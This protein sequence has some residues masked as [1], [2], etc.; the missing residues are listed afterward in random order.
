[1]IKPTRKIPGSGMARKLIS[2]EQGFRATFSKIG[3][4]LVQ[5]EN[6][7]FVEDF[8]KSSQ[9]TSWRP[10]FCACGQV[11]VDKS[12]A[13]LHARLRWKQE[14]D[15]LKTN[16]SW[17]FMQNIFEQLW[18]ISWTHLTSQ[19]I[20]VAFEFKNFPKGQVI[21]LSS[22]LSSAASAM[23]AE[24]DTATAKRSPENA[25]GALAE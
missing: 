14:T 12:K 24:D 25:L 9:L 8:L 15:N 16:I 2:S 1:M 3:S 19:L 6:H 13:T 21:H 11:K 7:H 4:L 18:L 10:V 23:E 17:Y 20:C 22:S 5:V